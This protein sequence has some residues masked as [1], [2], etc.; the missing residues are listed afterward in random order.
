MRTFARSV[1]YTA[2]GGS[3]ETREGVFDREHEVIRSDGPGADFSSTAPVLGIRLADWD[4]APV[5]GGVIA[6]D[7]ETFRVFD[8]QPDGQGGADVILKKNI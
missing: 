6:I 3:P 8:V 4:P 1:T 5:K 7:A 2:P